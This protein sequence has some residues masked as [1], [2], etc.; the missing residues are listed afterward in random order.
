[1]ANLQIFK[2]FLQNYFVKET[3]ENTKSARNMMN[4]TF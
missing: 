3:C 2:C 4:Y 1:M